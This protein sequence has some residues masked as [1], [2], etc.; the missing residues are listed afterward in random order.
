MV[1]KTW[2]AKKNFTH[3]EF[4]NILRLFDAL[5]N[6]DL[7]TWSIR[8]ASRVAKQLKIYDLKKLVN[9]RRVSKLHRMIA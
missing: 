8:V 1:I 6:F 3:N 2:E 7:R 5:P 9:V 4:I